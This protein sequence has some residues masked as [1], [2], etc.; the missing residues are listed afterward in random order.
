MSTFNVEYKRVSDTTVKATLNLIGENKPATT[1]PI[2]VLDVSGSMSGNRIKYC[3]DAIRHILSKVGH[4]HLLTYGSKCRD[5]G[6]ITTNEATKV[7]IDGMTSF[8]A[9][10][11]TLI[12]VVSRKSEP[13]QVIFMTDGE[14]TVR[15]QYVNSDRAWLK[16]KL[17]GKTCIIHTIGIECESHTQHML[18]LSRC[19]SSE[20]TYGYFS[21][22]IPNSYILEADRLIN[23]LG[24]M[25]EVEFNGT[26]YFIGSEPVETYIQNTDM[27]C[28]AADPLEEISYLAYRVNE[29]IRQGANAQLKDV[30]VVREHAQLI[31]DN[32]GRQPRVV[33]K[34]LREHLTPVHDLIN[35]FYQ[36][37]NTRNIT[38]EKL[39]LLNV[40]ARDARSSRFTKKVVDRTDQN[41]VILE[42]EDSDLLALTEE[43]LQI[44]LDDQPEDLTCMLTCM[45]PAELLRDG[46]CLGL[47]ICATVREAC[48]V[49]PT[50]LKVDS[51]STSHFGCSA[52]LEAA[53]YAAKKKNLHY[54]DNTNVVVDSSRTEVSGVLPLYLNETHW[55]V[56]KLYLRRM[57]GHLCC[58]D[59]L[60]GTNRIIFYTY[61]HA[62][63]FCRL[64][65]GEFYGRMA[66][67][68]RETLEHVYEKMQ[69]IIP[70]PNSFCDSISQRMPDVVPSVTL[71]EEAYS[72]LSLTCD[73]PHLRE[74]MTEEKLRRKKNSLSIQDV[75]IVDN[76]TWVQP[77]V[78]ANTPNESTG[79]FTGL[80]SNVTSNYPD[81]LSFLHDTIGS[82]TEMSKVSDDPTIVIIDPETYEPIIN[83]PN[84]MD[85]NFVDLSPARRAVIALQVCNL[86]NMTDC[87]AKYRNIFTMPEDEV[88]SI[89]KKR[90][91]EYITLRR[92]SE[93][94]SIID[95]MRRSTTAV[96]TTRLL[97]GVSL[98]ERVAILT[99]N[100][101]IGRNITEFFRTAT[102]FEE[103]KMLVIGKYDIAPLINYPHP[104][105]I[106]TVMDIS[107]RYNCLLPQIGAIDLVYNT[108][109]TQ[110]EYSNSWLPNRQHL[111][112]LCR[113]YSYNDL[114]SIMPHAKQFLDKYCV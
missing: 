16:E 71:L 99:N 7:T 64:Q 77:F 42:R 32:A 76:T 90:A 50:L 48:I 94:T 28:G 61:L 18:D 72:A 59:P 35:N 58:K 1:I 93:L 54:G 40:A 96:H 62:Y 3:L 36:M 13:C 27:E 4:I 46:D 5:H 44:N 10:Y 70:T 98:L 89:L 43:F 113:T 29:L 11:E 66:G 47:G 67:L 53:E 45:N 103:L 97:R 30:Q 79:V 82:N 106:P 37:V 51:I 14:D 83:L 85:E 22:K 52:F 88:H 55:K 23:I 20:G 9:A 101:Y 80:I 100:C 81:A 87:I 107:D 21:T 57:A 65:D 8:R 31:F 24:C 6:I 56:A 108:T 60:L 19:G 39:A 63:R 26:K 104:V 15:R 84:W 33:R 109:T 73:R 110:V 111:K 114:M 74:Y 38:H 75:C 68:L 86:S 78:R 102:T 95:S 12:A 34:M 91:V 92:T 17:N 105:I 49:D 69:T 41:L 25:A 112:K 2:V